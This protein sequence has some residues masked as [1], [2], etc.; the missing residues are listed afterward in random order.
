MFLFVLFNAFGLE[1]YIDNN[2][3]TPT[4]YTCVC[5]CV[6]V[7]VCTLSVQFSSVAQSCLT[8]CDPMNTARQA[9]LSITNCRSLPKPMSI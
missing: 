4:F 9:S 1:F 2:A 3:G 6:C 7:C 8:L 5:V